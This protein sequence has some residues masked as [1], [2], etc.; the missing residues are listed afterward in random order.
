MV[1]WGNKLYLS[2]ST[3]HLCLVRTDKN[4]CGI[5]VADRIS[6]ARR[7]GYS[8]MKSSFHGSNSVNPKVSCRMYQTYVMPCML[9]VYMYSLEILDPS[10]IDLK[11]LSDFHTE[12]IRR[13]QSLPS[14][15]ALSAVYLLVG[16]LPLEAELHKRQ[17]SLSFS[18]VSSRNAWLHELV[19]T[20][21]GLQGISYTGFFKR[22]S[23]TL[24]LY[25]LHTIRQLLESTPTKLEW[26]RQTRQALSSYWTASLLE[27]AQTKFNSLQLFPW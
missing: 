5:N 24:N 15:T 19:Q 18:I 12:L 25:D 13:I 16:A 7:T 10:K 2:D 26:K 8:L 23:D 6:L 4:D 14:R 21:I 22:V 9:H 27:E 11:Q 17:L 3:T 1:Y 20:A